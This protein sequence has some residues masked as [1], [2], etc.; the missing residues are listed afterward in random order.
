MK[1]CN[2]CHQIKPLESFYKHPKMKDGYHNRCKECQNSFNMLKKTRHQQIKKALIEEF[3]G[4]CIRCG[5]N[6]SYMAMDFHH[7]DPLTKNDSI[8][9]MI[10]KG[11]KWEDILNEAHKCD[12]LC[13]NCHREEHWLLYEYPTTSYKGPGKVCNMCSQLKPYSAFDK[14]KSSKDGYHYRCRDCIK[15]YLHEKREQNKK[16]LVGML[17]GKCNCCGYDKC[18][19]ALDFHHIDESTKSFDISSRLEKDP[20]L[21]EQ[22]LKKCVLW[23]SNCHREKHSIIY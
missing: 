7:R 8:S 23:C 14:M 6:K 10:N 19:G 12:L 4:K 22:E 11:C 15:L 9:N 18:L 2:L 3:G 20:L 13:S 17:G 21:L 1:E 5:Y 16:V